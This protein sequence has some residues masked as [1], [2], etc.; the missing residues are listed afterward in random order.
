HGHYRLALRRAR[1]DGRSQNAESG[2]LE[3]DIMQF[4]AIEKPLALRIANDRIVLPTI[5]KRANGG[6][7]VQHIAVERIAIRRGKTIERADCPRRLGG[8]FVMQFLRKKTG[9]ALA[10]IVQRGD[11]GGYMKR[12][13]KIDGS[14][15]D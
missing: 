11:G 13:Q 9:P 14:A 5:P 6:D 12:L 3:I 7:G 2:S 8:T 1:R 15:C 4:F 10:H